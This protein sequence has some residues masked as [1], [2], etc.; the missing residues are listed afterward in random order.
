MNI[1]HKNMKQVSRDMQSWVNQNISDR[2]I[3]ECSYSY[4]NY[5]DRTF[6]SLPCDYM[7]Y[8][9]YMEKSL[10]LLSSYRIKNGSKYWDQE[11]ELY[12]NYKKNIS[13]CIGSKTFYKLDILNKMEH[14]FEML[15]IGSFEPISFQS[16]IRINH[17]FSQL[18][19]HAHKI[20][21]KRKHICSDLR[22]VD[23]IRDIHIAQEK[24]LD[25]LSESSLKNYSKAKFDNLILTAKELLYIEYTMMGLTHKEIAARQQCSQTAVRKVLL[26]I[27]FKLGFSYMPNSQMMSKLKDVGVLEVC[28]QQMFK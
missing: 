11:S 27:K 23:E 26:N 25:N 16:H 19:L 10:D 18:S 20:R 15:A 1:H 14:G 2:N 7:W 17:L 3:Y 28:M 12:K 22:Q 5:F 8:C 4:Y 13:N 6:M 24:K 21:K 9:D